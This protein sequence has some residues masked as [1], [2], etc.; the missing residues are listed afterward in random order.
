MAGNQFLKAFAGFFIQVFPKPFLM[1]GQSLHR[2]RKLGVAAETT[3][4]RVEIALIQFM[5]NIVPSHA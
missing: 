2:D 5:D 3:V 4:T 1:C